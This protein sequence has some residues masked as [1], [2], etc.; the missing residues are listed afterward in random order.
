MNKRQWKKNKKKQEMFIA[1]WVHSYKELKKL[2]RSYHEFVVSAKR[3][4]YDEDWFNKVVDKW[5]SI[6]EEFIV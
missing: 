1:S 3:R 2:D 6:P 5:N 4:K